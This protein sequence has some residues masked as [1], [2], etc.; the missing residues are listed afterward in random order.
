M[1]GMSV[2]HNMF[3]NREVVS[4]WGPLA[5]LAEPGDEANAPPAYL[6]DIGIRLPSLDTQV[7][8][9]VGR[10]TPGDRD[11]AIDAFGR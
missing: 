3:L 10:S 4:G 1:P 2:Y 9:P 5:F 8:S 7:A 11:R 6:E